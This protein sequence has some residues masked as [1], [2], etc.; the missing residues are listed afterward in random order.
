MPLSS[1]QINFK[2][3]FALNKSKIKEGKQ[4]S[5]LNQK[6]FDQFVQDNKRERNFSFERKMRNNKDL[7][8]KLPLQITRKIKM[9]DFLQESVIN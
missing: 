4:G 5:L 7:V 3:K 8:S 2:P 9:F 6:S 1:N